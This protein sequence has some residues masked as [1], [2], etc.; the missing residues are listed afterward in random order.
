MEKP[1]VSVIIPV[2]N[3]R[4][5]ITETV[6]SVLNQ[7]FGSFEIIVVDDGSTDNTHRLLEKNKKLYKMLM[8]KMKNIVTSSFQDFNLNLNKNHIEVNPTTMQTSQNGIYAI[9]DIATYQNKIK[10][11][12]TGFAESATACHDIYKIIFPNQLFHFEYSTSKGS[13]IES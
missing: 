2:Y 3:K 7:D 12:L 10:L 13:P 1:I 8:Q 6:N 9:G 11:I 5:Y 4:E